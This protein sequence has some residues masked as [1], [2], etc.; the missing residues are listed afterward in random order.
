[1]EDEDNYRLVHGGRGRADGGTI[2]WGWRPGIILA[3]ML[4]VWSA[5]PARANSKPALNFSPISFAILSPKTQKVIGEGH[6]SIEHVAGGLILTGENRYFDGSY[7]VEVD[8]M[9]TLPNQQVPRL[10]D[11]RHIFYNRHGSIEREGLADMRTGD[12][13]CE[14]TENGKRTIETGRFD[15][16][17]DTYAGASILI[18]IQ[19]HLTRGDRT[20]PLYLHDF[21]CVPGPKLL[22]VEAE[23]QPDTRWTYHAG[24]LVPVKITP[25]FGFWTMFVLPFVPKITAWFDPARN[26]AFVGAQLA[27]YYRGPDIV[28]VDTSKPHTAANKAGH[29]AMSAT[30]KRKSP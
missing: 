12:C 16:P 6:Y 7:D 20:T 5:I 17:P 22:R 19:N 10:V 3:V 13:S 24:Q 4:L 11:F 30:I 23:P 27:R 9:D 2:G 18:P 14:A 21:N 15:F 8:R 25:D 1:M 29:A 28:M 26:W